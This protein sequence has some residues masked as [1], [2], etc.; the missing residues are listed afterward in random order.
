MFATFAFGVAVG[1]LTWALKNWTQRWVAYGMWNSYGARRFGLK[2]GFEPAYY[3]MSHIDPY[4][5]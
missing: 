5:S 2:A 3:A 1:M 4:L